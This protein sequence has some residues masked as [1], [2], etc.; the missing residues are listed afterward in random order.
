MCFFRWLSPPRSPSLRLNAGTADGPRLDITLRALP[1]PIPA[2]PSS[3]SPSRGSYFIPLASAVRTVSCPVSPSVN[4]RK[5]SPSVMT[6]CLRIAPLP[7]SRSLRVY[8]RCSLYR[9]VS[10]SLSSCRSVARGVGG[11][12]YSSR[13]NRPPLFGLYV[14]I[15]RSS[16]NYALFFLFRDS[17]PAFSFLISGRITLAHTPIR[18]TRVSSF[19]YQS[20]RST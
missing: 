16:L 2:N 19:R 3:V 7:G 12:G 17:L 14:C 20:P 13:C 15:Y 6:L 8:V 5:R 18:L 9:I 1:V 4:A 11:S 10:T